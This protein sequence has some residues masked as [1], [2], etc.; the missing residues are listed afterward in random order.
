MSEMLLGSFVE[1]FEDDEFVVVGI[2][3]RRNGQ[4]AGRF[5]IRVPKEAVDAA[6]VG[7]GDVEQLRGE[8]QSAAQRV[9]KAK[10]RAT[11]A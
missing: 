7:A 4:E 10:A 5:E 8:L 1:N 3:R 11:S 9:A 2:A 6:I